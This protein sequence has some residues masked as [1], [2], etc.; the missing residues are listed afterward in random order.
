MSIA[1]R[2][3]T[4]H[5]PGGSVED[6]KKSK[7]RIMRQLEA[8]LGVVDGQTAAIKSIAE[9][10][11]TYSGSTKTHPRRRC[12]CPCLHLGLIYG[13]VFV[14]AT[15]TIATTTTTATAT[16]TAATA[17]TIANPT[18]TTTTTTPLHQS[19][20]PSSKILAN[21]MSV[22]QHDIGSVQRRLQDIEE[23]VKVRNHYPPTCLPTCLPTYLPTCLAMRLLNYLP[24]Y[25]PTQPLNHPPTHS[26]AYPPTPPPHG[27]GPRVQHSGLRSR[28][29]RRPPADAA[30]RLAPNLGRLV[31]AVLPPHVGLER[32]RHHA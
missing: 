5:T 29:Q 4:P 13:S 31:A 12:L 23:T 24:T 15:A 28:Q 8:P 10:S 25:P 14:A 9:V 26:T 20:D 3:P 16:T 17:T 1:H 6:S 21:S 32:A 2:T 18:T 11:Y 22:M 19:T 30:D 7:S 27:Q